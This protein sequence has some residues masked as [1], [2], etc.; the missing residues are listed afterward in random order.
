MLTNT[1]RHYYHNAQDDK[2]VAT[3]WVGLGIVLGMLAAT[4]L[5]VL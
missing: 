4:V 5:G 1:N 2:W 3:A